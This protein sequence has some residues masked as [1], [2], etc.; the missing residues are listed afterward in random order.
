MTTRKLHTR[1]HFALEAQ[2]LARFDSSRVFALSWCIILEESE[3]SIGRQAEPLA[4]VWMLITNIQPRNADREMV[5]GGGRQDHA[6]T[7]VDLT[8]NTG[9]QRTRSKHRGIGSRARRSVRRLI[10]RLRE[11][12]T[13][14]GPMAVTKQGARV[15]REKDSRPRV[16]DQ[17]R[18]ARWVDRKDVNAVYLENVYTDDSVEVI[19]RP[20]Q[21][22]I[23]LRGLAPAQHSLPAPQRTLAQI[24]AR[25]MSNRCSVCRA[26][27]EDPRFQRGGICSKE[28]ARTRKLRGA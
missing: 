1:R 5:H 13:T 15:Y 7:T 20:D 18:L 4:A 8:G 2:K 26:I 16:I 23:L 11:N 3:S 12:A 6:S 9:R 25:V 21:T 27:I 24:N 10:P 28:C 14:V 19:H 22:P 17:T